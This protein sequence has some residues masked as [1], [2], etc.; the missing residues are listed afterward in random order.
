M[1]RPT[2]GREARQGTPACLSEVELVE[3]K[4]AAVRDRH[5]TAFVQHL[6]N[7]LGADGEASVLL[8]PA[9]LVSMLCSYSQ[10]DAGTPCTIIVNC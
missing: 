1:R 6:N 5:W 10:Y 4:I 8:V 7:G 9:L 2:P 3:P